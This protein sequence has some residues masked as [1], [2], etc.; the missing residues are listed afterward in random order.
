MSFCFVCEAQGSTRHGC[1]GEVK[2]LI[3]HCC[4]RG[5]RLIAAVLVLAAFVG[6][7]RSAATDLTAREVAERVFQAKPGER[8][9]FA[10]KNFSLIDLS[11]LDFKG[12]VLTGSDLYGTD[13]TD[14]N[15]AGA[16]LSGTRLDRATIIRTDFSKADL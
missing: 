5:S 14:A 15:L 8:V 13:L 9:D 1:G 10:D 6:G 11:R 4:R 3:T 2:S 16:N 12:A 7:D